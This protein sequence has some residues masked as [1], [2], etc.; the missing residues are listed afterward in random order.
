MLID[1]HD[2]AV[3]APVWSLYSAT[4]DRLGP[5]ATMI[6]RD[7]QIPPLAELLAELDVARDIAE[8]QMRSA[9]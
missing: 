9:A 7:D 2:Q 3:P 6:E 5:V 1:T 8:R 4:L